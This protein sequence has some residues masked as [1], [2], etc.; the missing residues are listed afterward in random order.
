[1]I[2]SILRGRLLKLKI[3]GFELKIK[4]VRLKIKELMLKIIC[5]KLK[6]S[7]PILSFNSFWNYG[8]PTKTF[9]F[10]SF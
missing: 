9:C 5:P 7:A 3:K 4:W 2:L 6:I 1:V 8:S 10:V